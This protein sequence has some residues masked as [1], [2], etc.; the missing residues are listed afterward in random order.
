MN[1][2]TNSITLTN[3][4]VNSGT[5]MK[6]LAG[7]IGYAWETLSREYPQPGRFTIAPTLF[8]GWKNPGINIT[9]FIQIT[10]PASSTFITYP[11]LMAVLRDRTSPTYLTITFSDSD[12]LFASYASSSSG[13]TS[14]PI[15]IKSVN[16][17]MNPNDN[18]R[19]D[20]LAIT[21]NCIESPLS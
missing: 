7:N 1:N 14:I 2:M 16:I 17:A 15:Q 6:L 20:L 19:A 8:Q 3:A 13:V 11:Q 5:A 18:D 10:N 4:A 21:L 12:T 9:F